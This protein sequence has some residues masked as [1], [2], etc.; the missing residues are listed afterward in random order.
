MAERVARVT[1]SRDARNENATSSAETKRGALPPHF[2][3]I[4]DHPDGVHGNEDDI[5]RRDGHQDRPSSGDSWLYGSGYDTPP[6]TPTRNRMWE[7]RITGEEDKSAVSAPSAPSMLTLGEQD[8]RAGEWNT[9]ARRAS[10]AAT[11]TKGR[12]EINRST[13]KRSRSRESPR[14]TRAGLAVTRRK[15]GPVWEELPKLEPEP[16]DPRGCVVNR[17]S[18]RTIIDHPRLPARC[19]RPKTLPKLSSERMARINQ[20]ATPKPRPDKEEPSNIEEHELTFTPSINRHNRR[21]TRRPAFDP[22]E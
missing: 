14:L 13:L 9:A 18:H 22:T 10:G 20:L 19:I 16:Y 21:T 15:D 17:Y 7:P 1:R 8:H 2:R 11:D 6:D 5:P 4:V 3:H 12:G